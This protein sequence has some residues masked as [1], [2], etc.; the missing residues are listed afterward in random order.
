MNNIRALT[1]G[2]RTDGRGTSQDD[3]TNGKTVEV[4]VVLTS[5][6][7]Q[8]SVRQGSSEEEFSN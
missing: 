3:N 2:D 6:S 5:T 8:D 4:V 1:T 7:V